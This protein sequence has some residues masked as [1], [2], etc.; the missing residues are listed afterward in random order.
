MEESRLT[1][2]DR[3]P[4]SA[5]FS[6]LI[7]ELMLAFMGLIRA[8]LRLAQA[9]VTHNAREAGKDALR[10][11]IFA[12]IA[13]LGVIALMSF[14]VIGLGDLL[15]GRYWLSSLIVTVL[16]LGGGGLA[17]WLAFRRIGSD[18]K[19]PSIQRNLETD[20]ELISQKVR[21]ISTAPRTSQTLPESTSSRRNP[22]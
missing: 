16:F 4:Q 17:S 6:A 12:A 9:E 14:L 21:D 7:R 15:N 11:L 10:G 18:A 20:R 13:L 19:A 3:P 5:S 8:E 1:S 22:S 2:T